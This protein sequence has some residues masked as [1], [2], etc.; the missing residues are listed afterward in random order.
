MGAAGIVGSGV[1]GG[2]GGMGEEELADGGVDEGDR[3]ECESAAVCG[4]AR[5][6]ACLGEGLSTFGYS[7]T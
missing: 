2:T 6:V 4:A 3:G 7:V 1:A 5:L